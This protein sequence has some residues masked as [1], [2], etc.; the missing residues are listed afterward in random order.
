MLILLGQ[1]WPVEDGTGKLALIF[2]PNNVSDCSA[3][4]NKVGQLLLG[5]MSLCQLPNVKEDTG[6]IPLN[7]CQ[8]RPVLQ[9]GLNVPLHPAW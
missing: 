8:N 6:K 3:V 2:S 1:L 7:I 5:Q 4:M 9:I